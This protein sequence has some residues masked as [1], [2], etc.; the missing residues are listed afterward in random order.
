[1]RGLVAG[2]AGNAV[3]INTTDAAERV[4]QWLLP[5]EQVHGAFQFVRDMI[6]L[7]SHRYM[8]IDLQGIE[9][10]RTVYLSVP[11][12]RVTAF[13]VVTPSRIDLDAE[14][15]LWVLGMGPL[16]ELAANEGCSIARKFHYDSDT[17]GIQQ[18]LADH[19]CGTR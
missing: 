16:D 17:A 1:M 12:S 18:V 11:W 2:V 9:G 15:L 14:M 10:M 8:E 13:A 3:G 19:V 6:L 4:R 5:N 7:T